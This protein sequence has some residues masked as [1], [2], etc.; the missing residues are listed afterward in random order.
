E[1]LPLNKES[2][3]NE[4][5]SNLRREAEHNPTLTLG[6]VAALLTAAG[7]FIEASGNAK[8]SYAY[9]RDVDRRVKR[10]AKNK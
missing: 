3:M 1:T 7:K 2:P 8:G 10:D 9:A 6:V 5:L 4:F